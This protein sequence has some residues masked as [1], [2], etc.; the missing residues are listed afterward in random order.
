MLT[1]RSL[2][3]PSPVGGAST[4]LILVTFPKMCRRITNPMYATE[5]KRIVLG[6]IVQPS[7]SSLKKDKLFALFPYG[8]WPPRGFLPAGLALLAAI[9]L[10][11]SFLSPPS[12]ADYFIF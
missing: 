8:A 9:F 6:D 1:H 3:G 10:A 5:N 7:A 11:S 4:F 12:I 2:F